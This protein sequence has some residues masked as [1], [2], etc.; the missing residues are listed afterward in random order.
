MNLHMICQ[1]QF[2]TLS[3][4]PSMF[5][6]SV[7]VHTLSAEFDETWNDYEK[8]GVFY[9]DINDP[10]FA[11]MEENTC[12]IPHE[13]M[14][15]RSKLN[16]G[17]MGRLGDKVFT[18]QIVRVDV[19][20]GAISQ[21]L[22]PSDPTPTVWEQLLQRYDY[23]VSKVDEVYQDQKN[24]EEETDKKRVQFEMKI[25]QQQTVFKDEIKKDQTAFINETNEDREEYQVQLAQQV[26]TTIQEA[27]EATQNVN[28]ALSSL[29]QMFVDMDGGDPFTNFEDG[30]Y[31]D[32]NGGYPV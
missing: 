32:A 21:N 9:V 5:S 24:F 28:D 7:G 3:V 26:G 25:E 20:Q 1:G 13:V 19:G 15:K 12:V 10:Y 2:A 17:I 22:Q 18:S 4:T 23:I 29:Q 11:F 6:G 14:A 31:V 30:D 27:R 8:I 16:I